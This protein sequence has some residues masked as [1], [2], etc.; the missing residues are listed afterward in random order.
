[1][2]PRTFYCISNV[3]ADTTIFGDGWVVIGFSHRRANLIGF[4]RKAAKKKNLPICLAITIVKTPNG[5]VLLK[6]HEGV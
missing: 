2:M 4:D 3:G 5:K 1:M 6:A